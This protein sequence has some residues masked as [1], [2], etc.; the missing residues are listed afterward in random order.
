VIFST[1]KLSAMKKLI[2][3]LL[4]GFGLSVSLFSQTAIRY[5]ITIKYN[6]S[7]ADITVVVKEGEPDFTY[8]LMTNDPLKGAVLM[9]SEPT[10][11]KTYVFR[12]V[13]PGKYFVKIEDHQGLPAGKTIEIIEPS[14]SS[15]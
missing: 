12:D 15:N 13:K 5:E 2:I 8:F 14:N 7:Q 1:V 11:K 6:K 9:Q 4:L 3:T 10:G